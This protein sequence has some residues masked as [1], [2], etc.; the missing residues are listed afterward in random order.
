[1]NWS[2]KRKFLYACAGVIFVSTLGVYFLRGV[3][4][5]EPTC[6]DGKMNGFE[7]SVD[8]GGTCALKC[9]Q[10]VT[11]LVVSWSRAIRTGSTTYDV[12]AMIMNKNTDNASRMLQYKI[13][14][15]SNTGIP[16]GSFTGSTMAYLD[17]D[18]PI[19]MQNVSATSGVVTKVVTELFDQPHYAIKGKSPVPVI[20][21]ANTRYEPGQVTR[22]YSTI[23][24]TKQLTFE[25]LPVKVVL[26]D[27]EDNAYAVGETLI[28]FLNKEES[29]DISFIWPHLLKVAPTKIRVYPL[30]DPFKVTW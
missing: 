10:E 25:N 17:G 22:V 7:V 15:Y 20:R 1:M 8:C 16:L 18:F 28:P 4:I 27:A 9:T 23:V 13:T 5:K 2:S 29:K 12:V 30:I 26:F 6:S 11:P 14:L 19:I 21:V 24:N 3:F